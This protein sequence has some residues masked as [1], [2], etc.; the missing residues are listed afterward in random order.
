METAPSQKKFN[1]SGAGA[2]LRSEISSK[3][4]LQNFTPDDN[5]TAGDHKQGQG[6]VG[7][8]SSEENATTESKQQIDGDRDNDTMCGNEQENNPLTVALADSLLLS[9]PFAIITSHIQ[10]PAPALLNETKEYD[11]FQLKHELTAVAVADSSFHEESNLNRVPTVK[12]TPATTI[13]TAPVVTSH[14]DNNSPA[15][16][17]FSILVVD[18][19]LSNRKLLCKLL[20]S[21]GH[22]CDQ[23][24]DGTD[25]VKQVRNSWIHNRHDSNDKKKS[26]YDI[27]CMD[28]Q[29]PLMDGPTAVFEIRAMG[30][31]GLILGVTGNAVKSDIELFKFKGADDVVIKP[32]NVEILKRAL[33]LKHIP[34]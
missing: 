20:Q 27:I 30:F 8:T 23:A 26:K 18:D 19:S 32:V 22:T 25:A 24:V 6:E 31:D 28:Y 5:E 16:P 9:D 1:G 29:M 4:L 7:R 12:P 15:P 10:A 3:T 34:K 2:G 33:M 13:N 21:Q 14:K 17:K 11:E